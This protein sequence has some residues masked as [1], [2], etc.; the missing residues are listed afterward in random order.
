M[1]SGG[2]V[3]VPAGTMRVSVIA[4]LESA[5]SKVTISGNTDL[6]TGPNTLIVTVTAPSGAQVENTIIVQVAEAPS[7]T[8][9]AVFTVNDQNVSDGSSINVSKGTSRVRVSAIAEDA[10]A[11]VVVTG[12]SGLSSGANYLTVTVTALSGAST[13]YTVTVNV[14][15]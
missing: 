6:E 4:V 1:S 2:T 14:G 9:L 7:N 3:N 12:K 11:S 13:T 8:S 10:K 5:E 15:N